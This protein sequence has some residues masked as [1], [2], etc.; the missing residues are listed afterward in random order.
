MTILVSASAM[1]Y[2]MEWPLTL[3]TSVIFPVTPRTNHG[4]LWRTTMA[5]PQRR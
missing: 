4:P 2:S 3:S 1:A 5:V